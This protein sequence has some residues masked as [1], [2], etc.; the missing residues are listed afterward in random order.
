MAAKIAATVPGDKTFTGDIDFTGD[1]TFSG[2]AS[3]IDYS[4]G[5]FYG[6]STS[7]GTDAEHDIVI[8]VGG[9]RSY[10]D[11]ANIDPSS[12]LTVEVDAEFGTG[13]GGMYVGGTVAADT[14]Y[15]LFCLLYTSP[16]PRDGL[17]S[18]MPSSA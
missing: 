12:S 11:T 18:R 7:L 6:L 4:G 17:L 3:G 5:Y 13:D 2:G 16:S 15:H 8:A 1:I 10:G 14:T 9:C